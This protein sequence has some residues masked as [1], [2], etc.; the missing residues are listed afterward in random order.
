MGHHSVT[1]R[2]A[3]AGDTIDKAAELHFLVRKLDSIRAFKR[4][5]LGALE[6]SFSRVSL[7]AFWEKV[8]KDVE[9]I[10]FFPNTIPNVLKLIQIVAALRSLFILCFFAFTLAV[11][12]L[13][14]IIPIYNQV[15]FI[16][17]VL[18]PAGIMLSYVC[19]DFMTRKRIVVYEKGHVHLHEQEKG[20]IKKVIDELIPR[21]ARQI[22]IKREDPAKYQMVLFFND[23]QGIKTLKQA[24]PRIFGIFKRSYFT[25][26]A[27]PIP[28][29]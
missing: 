11:L 10:I 28:K 29:R 27:I 20:R 9:T 12:M 26:T 23:Y 15:F 1:G 13:M 4:S 22:K 25:Y 17:L 18:F 7:T 21:L 8:Q 3:Q 24:R 6:S 5:D 19:I 16:F 14:K 2:D